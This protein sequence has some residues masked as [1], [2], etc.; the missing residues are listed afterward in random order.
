[1]IRA[2]IRRPVAVTM[3]YG[4]VAALGAFAWRNI[5]MEL[6]PDTQLPPLTVSA[7]W[8]G[9]SP[10]TVEAF[11]TSPIEAE[12]QQVKGVEKVTSY[13]SD[14]GGVGLSRVEI[15]F[16]RDTDMD[17]ARLELSERMAAL[18]EDLP[19]T[20]GAVTVTPY[21]PQELEK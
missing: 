10:E 21:V 9:S 3:V 20:V 4:A 2:S 12:I 13:S 16:A 5:P 17:F 7:S 1:M 19:P 6:L 8:H 15:E 11:L 18:E 14:Q